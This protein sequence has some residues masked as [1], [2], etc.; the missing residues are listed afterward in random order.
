[1]TALTL[2]IPSRDRPWSLCRC[3]ASVAQAA[4]GWPVEILVLDQSAQA[5]AGP[6][7]W[8][9]IH[10][11]VCSGLPA[12]RNRL[13]ALARSPVVCFL[14]DDVEVA[15]DFVAVLLT[16]VDREPRID[17]WGPV[18]ECRSLWRRRWH[19]LLQLGA[20]RDPRRLI[21][22]ACDRSSA[23]L[24]GCCFAVRRPAALACGAFDARRR[25]YA[26]GE[27]LDFFLRLRAHGGQIRFVADLRAIHHHDPGG[28]A[29]RWGHLRCCAQWLHLL[30]RRHG[31][32]N[33]V[34]LAHLAVAV[35]AVVVGGG[36]AA[37][38]T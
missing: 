10:D 2:A 31:A 6:G 15:E 18:V 23:A 25:G 1:M 32:H 7:P 16:L 14:D 35:L 13:L 27:D 26:L 34:S 12:A 30:A 5:L 21:A 37:R 22:R 29:N 8:R 24:F 9:I 36:R 3:L 11:P 33:P 28:R 38:R 19:R 4:A 20:L 17:A